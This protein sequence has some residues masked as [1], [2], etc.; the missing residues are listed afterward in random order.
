MDKN[1]NL[2][3]ISLVAVVAII[4]VI[5]LIMTTTSGHK[6]AIPNDAGMVLDDATS[7]ENLAGDAKYFVDSKISKAKNSFDENL[8]PMRVVMGF[9]GYTIIE[10]YT[11][12][13][14]VSAEQTST[15]NYSGNPTLCGLDYQLLGVNSESETVTI[16]IEDSQ[17]T[18]SEGDTVG[19]LHLENVF[20]QTIPVQ[21]AQ[22]EFYVA[23]DI[24]N[25]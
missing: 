10:T 5:S 1:N 6:T 18:L 14:P 2:A 4:G 22:A 7:S 11:Q 15:Y 3:L 16:I 13:I 19:P 17:Y 20:L 23:C 21:A 12:T 25:D 9:E 8:F 24:Y